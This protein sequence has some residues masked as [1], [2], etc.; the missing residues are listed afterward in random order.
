MIE[1]KNQNPEIFAKKDNYLIDGTTAFDLTYL[2]LFNHKIWFDNDWREEIMPLIKRNR[3]RTNQM[4][5]F[6]RAEG[7]SQK[8]DLKIQYNRYFAYFWCHALNDP[9]SNEEVI[10]DPISYF[11]EKGFR[12]LDLRLYNQV[13]CFDFEEARKLLMQGAKSNID[14]YEDGDSN[15]YF[16]VIGECSYLA[17][18]II[19]PEFEFFEEKGYNQDFD[20]TR[21]FGDLLGLAAHLEMDDL[22]S[23]YFEE[24]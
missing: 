5:D 2:T 24:D 3:R 20:I 7:E 6:W 15:T 19:I 14:F 12:E 10:L 8:L 9:E 17:T 22:L 4:I 13:E 18:C 16:R 21:M 11:L 1:F 23:E